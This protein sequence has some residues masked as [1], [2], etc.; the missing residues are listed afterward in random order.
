MLKGPGV[1]PLA[2][3]VDN[4]RIQS[5][6]EYTY[7]VPG[8]KV[9]DAGDKVAMAGI[10]DTHA[11][12]NEPGRTEWEGFESATRA[13]AS[14]GITTVIDM[15]L[16]S[17]PA[18]TSKSALKEKRQAAQGK[19]SI[20]YGFWGGVVPGNA[21][22][23]EGMVADNIMGAKCFL[24]NSG[25]PEFEHVG[26]DHLKNAMP[27]LKKCGVPLIVHAELEGETK[28]LSNLPND[29]QTYLAS[30]P[31]DFEVRAIAMM[32]ELCRQTGCKT[33]IVHLSSAE[34]LPLIRQAKKDGLPFTVE[35][36]PHYLIFNAE[37]IAQGHT[38][39]KCA[40]PIRH[41]KNQKALWQGIK[42]GLIDFIVSDHSPCTPALKLMEKGNFL[43]AWGGIAGLQFSLSAVWTQM[44]EYGLHLPDL[45]RLM[46]ANTARFIGLDKKKGRLDI[47]LDADV[48][49]FDDQKT[50]TVVSEQVFHRHKITPYQNRQLKGRVERTI[51][52][53]QEIF[54]L[55]SE[56]RAHFAAPVG[57]EVKR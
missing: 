57:L 46:A 3:L 55:D 6:H 40:P 14:G 8:L 36:C 20:D 27:I 11:H 15:P 54:W 39:F 31:D 28:L 18:T 21:G 33:H 37:E 48:I 41:L 53:G 47:G 30:R 42:E 52:R 12:I 35:T 44:Q 22:E 24:C 50:Y 56:E 38:H 19:C 43:E 51:L 9:I 25:V 4:S 2:M 7:T 26:A 23:L 49:I 13:A 45:T 34:A 10:V 1:Q 32:I 17:I 29:Y 5:F 16:N